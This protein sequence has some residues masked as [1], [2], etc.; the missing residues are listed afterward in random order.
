MRKDMSQF[1]TVFFKIQR[2][3]MYHTSTAFIS[4]HQ[5]TTFFL[6][7]KYNVNVTQD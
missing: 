6:N 3:E 2:L 7:E 4:K 1:W 5:A